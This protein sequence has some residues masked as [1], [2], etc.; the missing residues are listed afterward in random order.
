MT[1]C[2]SLNV[3]LLNSQL[4]NL[5][6]AIKNEAELVLRLSSNMV[7]NFNDEIIFPHKLILTNIPV[8]SLHKYFVN[9]L[10]TDIKLS[11]LRLS[12]MM[13]SGEF[14]GKI[15]GPLIKTRLPLM[16]NVIKP[17]PKSVLIPLGLT[18]AATAADAGIHKKYDLKH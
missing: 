5:K 17:L 7:G 12:K 4:S 6:S 8:A 16:E 11:K 13:Q 18:A 15:F 2:N 3:K 1:H 9:H 10:S 14:L